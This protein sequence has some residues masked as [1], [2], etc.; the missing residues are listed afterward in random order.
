MTGGRATRARQFMAIATLWL[1]R[2]S[3][4][5]GAEDCKEVQV[6]HGEPPG[7]QGREDCEEIQEV[8]R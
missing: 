4:S 2:R 8:A 5:R 6:A 1:V 3:G 7:K